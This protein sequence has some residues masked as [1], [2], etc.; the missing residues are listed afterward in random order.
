VFDLAST[1]DFQNAFV[2]NL[3]FPNEQ[4]V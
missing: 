2:A 4:D 3:S 1:P